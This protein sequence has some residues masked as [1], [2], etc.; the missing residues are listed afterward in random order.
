[1]SRTGSAAASGKKRLRL[2]CLAP[3]PPV[4]GKRR[5]RLRAGELLGRVERAARGSGENLPAPA[6]IRAA[7]PRGP[8]EKGGE[9]REGRSGRMSRSI[10]LARVQ[11][12]PASVSGI[13]TF[14]RIWAWLMFNQFLRTVP[15]TS[16]KSVE[17]N[18]FGVC[19]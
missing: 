19:R 6:A 12:S 5:L 3:A 4:R 7:D 14:D 8:A 18:A 15:K 2:V 10:P 13:R 11:Y 9:H 1:M 16:R 17:R